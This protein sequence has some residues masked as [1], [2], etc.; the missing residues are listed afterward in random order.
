MS[1]IDKLGLEL[2]KRIDLLQR[3]KKI[4]AVHHQPNGTCLILADASKLLL[5]G[6]SEDDSRKIVGYLGFYGRGEDGL[7]TPAFL[8]KP[9]GYKDHNIET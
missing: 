3:Q 5:E 1:L 4:M 2:L 8:Y 7:D 6:L 9:D